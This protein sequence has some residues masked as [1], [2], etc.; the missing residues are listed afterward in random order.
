[1]KK[2]L[3]T[4]IYFGLAAYL[5]FGPGAIW[6]QEKEKDKKKSSIEESISIV[7]DKS[8][9]VTQ[10]S[11]FE[12]IGEDLTADAKISINL[13]MEFIEIRPSET[14]LISSPVVN[15]ENGQA[16]TFLQGSVGKSFSIEVTPTIVKNQGIE[17]KVKFI[18]KP[19]MKEY[20]EKTVLA[21]NSQPVVIE[22]LEKIE[23]KSKLAVKITPFV[24]IKAE[25]KEYPGPVKELQFVRSFLV[26]NSDKLIAKGGLSIKNSDGEVLP[27]FFVQGKGIYVLSFQPFEGAKPQG[28]VKGKLMRIKLAEDEF[29][30][31]SQEPI[32]PEGLWYVWIR[33]N[34][35]IQ[36][37]EVKK[38]YMVLE[39]KNGFAGLLFGKDSWKK[40]FTK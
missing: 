17:L 7:K 22:L 40:F 39:T 38:T 20:K 16:V 32:L 37:S 12:D 36:A 21:G 6:S 29:D 19:E 5:I 3:S 27:Y 26:L 2:L 11:K 9:P 13:K 15:T 34:P 35:N 23:E 8:G 24:D 28:L 31:Y 25:A 10:L 30:W 33:H 18:K 4:S 14:K 1:M